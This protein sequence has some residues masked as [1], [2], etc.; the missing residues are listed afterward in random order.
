MN[1]FPPNLRRLVPLNERIVDS[2]GLSAENIATFAAVEWDK[3]FRKGLYK[4][5]IDIKP[6]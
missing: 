5:C 1:C 3:N 2:S 4:I 6:T